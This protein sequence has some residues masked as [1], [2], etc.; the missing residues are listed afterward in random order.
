MNRMGNPDNFFLSNSALI[1][2]AVGSPGR[3][4]F[5]KQS[6]AENQNLW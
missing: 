1:A 2:L 6:I 4:E 3:R 5:L